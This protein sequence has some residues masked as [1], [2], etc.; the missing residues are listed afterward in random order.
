[1]VKSNNNS[2]ESIDGQI[3]KLQEKKAALIEKQEKDVGKYLLKSWSIS[4]LSTEEI[5]KIIDNNKPKFV[6]ADNSKNEQ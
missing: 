6:P 4:S 2:L 1:M 5:Y 3:K